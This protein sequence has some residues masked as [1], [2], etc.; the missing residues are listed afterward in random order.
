MRVIAIV[1]QKGGCGKTTTTVNL[2]GALEADGARVLIV[3]LDP[4]A[5]ILMAW[6]DDYEALDPE[7][8]K[9]RRR[10]RDSVLSL[11]DEHKSAFPW[12][13]I[14]SLG[15]NYDPELF[16]LLRSRGFHG[17]LWQHL[18]LLSASR[19]YRRR[20]RPGSSIQIASSGESAGRVAKDGSWNSSSG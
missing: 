15:V 6:V 19:P 1:N 16:G 9:E 11:L 12:W 5:A 7:L 20:R 8:A 18:R 4:H 14:P 10:L 2:G 13:S 3:D 17:P